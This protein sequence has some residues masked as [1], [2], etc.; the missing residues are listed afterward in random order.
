MAIR[1]SC[2]CRAPHSIIALMACTQNAFD[3]V[4]DPD[5]QS[6]IPGLTLRQFWKMC[7]ACMSDP[8]ELGQADIE[9][10]FVYDR[11]YGFFYVPAGMH[12]QAM[13]LLLAFH[14]GLHSS[15]EVAK[16]LKLRSSHETADHWL[17]HVAGTAF[18][19]SQGKKVMAGRRGNLNALELRRLGVVDYLLSDIS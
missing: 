18:R 16:A 13:S 19:S 8:I 9:K 14:H 10:P 12:Q 6:H 7:D 4:D 15:V 5:G 17:E 2:P 11:R 1:S 3:P